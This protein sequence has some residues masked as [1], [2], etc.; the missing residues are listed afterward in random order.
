LLS[1]TE[2]EGAAKLAVMFRGAVE[3][4]GLPHPESPFDVVTISV[5]V[6]TAYPQGVGS[7]SKDLIDESD[8]ALYTAKTTGRNRVHQHAQS[9]VQRVF[10]CAL[11]QVSELT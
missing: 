3:R 2:S 7:T 5:G 6:A 9:A 10:D 4:L 8:A 1:N 11:R